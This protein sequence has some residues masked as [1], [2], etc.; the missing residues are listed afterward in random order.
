MTVPEQLPEGGKNVYALPE[1]EG[2]STGAMAE[3]Y[4]RNAIVNGQPSNVRTFGA[5]G[6]G[7]TDD[8]AAFQDAIDTNPGGAIFVPRIGRGVTTYRLDGKLTA[9]DGV[10]VICD[11]GVV[12]EFNDDGSDP[13]T[14][15]ASFGV[16]GSGSGVAL[17]ITAGSTFGSSALTLDD[18]SSLAA[19]DWLFLTSDDAIPSTSEYSTPFFFGM[20][21]RIRSIV[22]DDILIEGPLVRELTTSPTAVKVTL[23][24]QLRITGGTWRHTEGINHKTPI[25]SVLLGYQPGFDCSIEHNGGPGIK[26]SHC[27]E[28][29]ST[30]D[31]QD[32]TDNPSNANY[33]YGIALQ[34]STRG[35][36]VRGGSARRVRHAVTTDTSGY[37]FGGAVSGLRGDPE[38]NV[39]LPSFYVSDCVNAGLDTHEAGYGNMIFP[40]VQ[41]CRHGV[42]DRAT[43]TYIGPGVVT[44]CHLYGVH[45]LDFSVD[46][47]VHGVV[48]LNMDAG[49]ESNAA[50]FRIAAAGAIL[51]SCYFPYANG[52]DAINA[53][54][55]YE[56]RGGGYIVG[57]TTGAGDGKLK[58]SPFGEFSII[59][60]LLSILATGAV[61]ARNIRGTGTDVADVPIRSDGISG[62]TGD[63]YQGRVN[64]TVKFGV[65]AAGALKV[66]NAS[67]ATT[68]GTVVQK[69]EVFNAAGTSLGFVPVYNAIT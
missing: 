18:A 50:A 42:Q 38:A 49:R 6:D 1:Q 21:R 65:T 13:E 23:A 7:A 39:V 69:I 33:G 64:G 20:L 8:T 44:G 61:N 62:Q 47:V 17:S 26:L 54:E 25:F 41:N 10:H 35:F 66:G 58:F 52:V 11:Q 28:G 57:A 48:V 68:P 53:T 56:V 37:T 34:G 24:P 31:M 51:D 30:A 63:L 32:F 16:A 12:I 15:A 59:E 29:W 43:R 4:R 14:Q 2:A 67:S 22:G 5:V 3:L 19:G 55:D 40:N 45:L 46:P 9:D 60:D 36:I 27:V